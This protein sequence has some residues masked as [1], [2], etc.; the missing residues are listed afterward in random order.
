MLQNILFKIIL[1]SRLSKI[2]ELCFK[3]NGSLSSI[4]YTQHFI[5]IHMVFGTIKEKSNMKNPIICYNSTCVRQ[6]IH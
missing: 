2:Q 1:K 6:Q 5:S 4:C 3:H